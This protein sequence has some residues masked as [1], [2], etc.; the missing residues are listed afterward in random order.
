MIIGQ[1]SWVPA[2]AA[3]GRDDDGRAVLAKRTQFSNA[4]GTPPVRDRLLLHPTGREGERS[5]L[6]RAF[7]SSL[8]EL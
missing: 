2:L 6:K 1:C 7:C 4:S 5:E 3:L 8:S